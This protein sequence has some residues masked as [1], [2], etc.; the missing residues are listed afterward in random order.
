[1]EDLLIRCVCRCADDL[2]R[3]RRRKVFDM[4]EDAFT[5]LMLNAAQFTDVGRDAGVHE[6]I[7][8]SGIVIDW[9]GA[10]NEEPAAVVYLV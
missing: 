1:M 10:E 5:P 6:D 9:D 3:L 4:V 7:F 2:F 8:F